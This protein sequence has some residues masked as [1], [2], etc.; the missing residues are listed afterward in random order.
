MRL[1]FQ[2]FCL[3]FTQIQSFFEKYRDHLNHN[4]FLHTIESMI[5]ILRNIVKIDDV[6]SDYFYKNDLETEFTNERWMTNEWMKKLSRK[7]D[8]LLKCLKMEVIE[9]IK[10]N[11]IPFNIM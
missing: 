9:L 5:F 4:N 7:I 2:L 1:L 10:N 8:I 3:T 6:Q 11:V